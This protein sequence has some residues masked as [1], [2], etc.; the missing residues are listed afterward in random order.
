MT[1]LSNYFK[2]AFRNLVR[3][4]TYAIINISGIA[5][6]MTVFS[7]FGLYV[8]DELSYDRF[9]DKANRIVRVVHHAVWDGG[10]AHHAVTSAAFAPALKA[11]Y[12]EIEEATRIAPEGGV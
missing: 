2:I 11:A 5:V 8:A 12:P 6:G 9:H 7:L 4:R 1:M 3:N 10:E